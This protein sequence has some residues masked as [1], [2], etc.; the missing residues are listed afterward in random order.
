MSDFRNYNGH[1]W[2][3]VKKH[4]FEPDAS[5]EENYRDLE[6]H[7]I[8]ETQFLIDEVRKLFA[9]LEEAREIANEL[10]RQMP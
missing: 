4:K 2:I 6:K 7:H 1:K 5:W 3:K 8:E 9:E 10:E